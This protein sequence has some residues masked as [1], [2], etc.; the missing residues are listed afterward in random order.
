MSATVEALPRPATVGRTSGV[1]FRQRRSPV[2]VCTVRPD[3]VEEAIGALVDRMREIEKARSCGAYLFVDPRTRQA[4][5]VDE[6]RSIV[7]VWI[8]ERLHWLVGYYRTTR[9]ADP[10]IPVLRPTPEGLAED[11]GDHLGVPA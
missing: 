8:R 5:V 11:L 3:N 9:P 10:R 1:A 7:P 6:D 4:Y 2:P